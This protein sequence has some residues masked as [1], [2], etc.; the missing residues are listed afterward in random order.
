MF[1]GVNAL[2]FADVDADD[3]GRATA[4]SAVFQ[5]ITLALGVAFAGMLVEASILWRGGELGLANFQ[6][7]FLGVGAIALAGVI[8]ILRLEPSAG[9]AVSGHKQEQAIQ[10]QQVS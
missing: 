1:T 7:A 8:P 2:V 6:F 4:I 5:Q 3:A 10:G 9:S